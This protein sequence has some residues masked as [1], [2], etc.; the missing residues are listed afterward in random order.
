MATDLGATALSSA[1]ATDADADPEGV[2]S[3]GRF[4]YS[5]IVDN[6]GAPAERGAVVRDVTAG[7]TLGVVNVPEFSGREY[8]DVGVGE[9]VV[10]SNARS[11]ARQIIVRGGG[12]FVLDAA[13]THTG[14]VLVEAGELVIRNAAAIGSGSLDLR[15]GAKVTLDTGTARVTVPQ[16]VMAAGS[17]LDVGRG[18]LT[19]AAGGYTTTGL[20]QLLV[21]GRN[22]G[23]WNGAGIRT[24]FAAPGSFRSIGYRVMNDG[25]ANVAWA[26][27]GDTNLDGRVNSTDVNMILSSGRFNSVATNGGWWQGDFNY[28]GRVNST[29]LNL[30]LG[31]GLLNAPSYLP[32][33]G[34]STSSSTSLL[35]WAAYGQSSTSTS[36]TTTP[37]SSKLKVTKP[38]P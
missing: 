23:Q 17:T 10:Y 30:L 11:G 35:A 8:V 32:A 6:A 12:T 5:L 20:R 22:G 27:F 13:N 28:D 31:T 15:A 4:V 1:F 38:L 37:T 2:S 19:I 16:L 18:G 25:S 3:P 34:S 24:Q 26:A 33:S 21:A 9:Q 29:D 36:N 7:F 14:G